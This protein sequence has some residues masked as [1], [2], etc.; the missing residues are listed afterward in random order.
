MIIISVLTD[1]SVSSRFFGESCF[2]SADVAAYCVV[3]LL[4]QIAGVFALC[5]F[6]DI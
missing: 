5:T 3:A 1:T 4:S 6:V 2:A